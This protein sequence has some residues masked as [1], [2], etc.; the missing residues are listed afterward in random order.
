MISNKISP[1]IARFRMTSSIF[2][3]ISCNIQLFSSNIPLPQSSD[4]NINTFRTFSAPTAI[5]Q[6]KS[7]KKTENCIQNLPLFYFSCFYFMF[8]C[9][10]ANVK[11]LSPV[12][13]STLQNSWKVNKNRYY[14]KISCYSAYFYG[15]SRVYEYSGIYPSQ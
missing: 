8:T 4:A 1:V 9:Q 11:Y 3:P 14:T 13:S 2:Q 15:Y 6:G 5:S 10:P 7:K 12:P